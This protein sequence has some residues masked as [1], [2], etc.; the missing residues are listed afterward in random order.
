MPAKDGASD[1]NGQGES[2][3]EDEDEDEEGEEDEE[4]LPEHLRIDPDLAHLTYEEMQERIAYL[5]G[6]LAELGE[7]PNSPSQ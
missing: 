3:E 5:R 7:D 2:E 1:E 6:R 4:D